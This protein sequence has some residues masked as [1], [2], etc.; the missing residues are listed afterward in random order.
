MV[1]A[2]VMFG[3]S[4]IFIGPHQEVA[5]TPAK[6]IFADNYIDRPTTP[7]PSWNVVAVR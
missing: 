2:L 6:V 4:N 1:I 7:V 3:L 5:S